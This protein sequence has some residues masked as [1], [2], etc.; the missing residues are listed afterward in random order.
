MSLRRFSSCLAGAAVAV[1][2]AIAGAPSPAS[3]ATD[4]T[5]DINYTHAGGAG[6]VAS[7][8]TGN[9]AWYN[10]SA[11]LTYITQEVKAGDCSYMN[12]IAVT[13]DAAIYRTTAPRCGGRYT[14]NNVNLDPATVGSSKAITWIQVQVIDTTHNGFGPFQELYRN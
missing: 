11:A 7:R 13:A 3:A 12:I 10:R 1:S 14:L 8:F 4:F 5:F 9:V 2:V 6:A